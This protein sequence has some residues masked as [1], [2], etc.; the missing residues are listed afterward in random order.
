VKNVKKSKV[1][2]PKCVK[3]NKIKKQKLLLASLA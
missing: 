2:N 3:Q 1:E